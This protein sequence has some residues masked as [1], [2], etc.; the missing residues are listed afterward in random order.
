MIKLGAKEKYLF[1]LAVKAK[2][3]LKGEINFKNNLSIKMGEYE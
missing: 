1:P 3:A 2:A